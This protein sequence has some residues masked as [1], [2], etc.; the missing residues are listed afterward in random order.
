MDVSKHAIPSHYFCDCSTPNSTYDT[1][2]IIFFTWFWCSYCQWTAPWLVVKRCNCMTLPSGFLFT[3]SLLSL[4]TSNLAP[5]TSWPFPYVPSGSVSE[6]NF[7]CHSLTLCIS[8]NSSLLGSVTPLPLSCTTCRR[9]LRMPSACPLF[10]GRNSS[11]QQ[12]LCFEP[13]IANE[14]HVRGRSRSWTADDMH[15]WLCPMT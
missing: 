2:Y 12:T 14:A 11:R 3:P 5:V 6:S 13:E 7:P 8:L 4:N 1:L 9:S 10:K 15:H